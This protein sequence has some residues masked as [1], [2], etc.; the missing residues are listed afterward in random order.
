MQ[1]FIKNLLLL[2]ATTLF[3][4]SYT[5][6]QAQNT[7]VDLNTYGNF[8][9]P[10][11][12]GYNVTNYTIINPMNGTSTP[13]KYALTTD[14]KLMNSTY[15][16][17]GDHTTGTGKMM[18]IDGATLDN[19]FFWTT[20]SCGC[21]IQGFTVG[22]TYTFSFWVKSVSND[23]T[24]LTQS[25]IQPLVPV[26]VAAADQNPPNIIVPLPALGWQ[27]V[28]FTFTAT[29]T[30]V[31]IRLKTMSI[32]NAGNDF[33]VD[34]FSII[35]GTL[36]LV[37]S[38]DVPTP[39]D[40]TCPDSSDGSITA[41]VNFGK[42]P[43]SYTITGPKT[44]TNTSGVFNSLPVG[45]Y[46]ISVKDS[47]SPPTTITQP[48]PITLSG[49]PNDLV[50][51]PDTSACPGKSTTLT[52][53]GGK[54]GYT[55]T[56]SPT[57]LSLTT[58]NDASISVSPTQTTTYTV[59]SGLTS[60]PTNFIANGDFSF[61][62]S[63]FT[64]DYKFTSNPA[65]N[66]QQKCYGIVSNPKTWFN[67]FSA[68][69]DHTTG[70]DKMFVA[71]GATSL[72]KVWSQNVSGLLPNQDYDFSY[73]IQSLTSGT[74]AKMEVL[75][76]GVSLGPLKNAPASNCQ[77]KL[78]KYIWNSG[79]NT[80]ATITIYNRDLSGG[81][82]DF[83]ID[84]IAFT[85]SVYCIFKKT[86]TITIDSSVD[87]II[88]P[89]G[90]VCSPV[91]VDI[92]D[93]SITAGS[94]LGTLS[95]WIDDQ[96]T[97]PLTNPDTISV[98]GTY[99]IKN[100]VSSCFIIK[101]VT[102][103][104]TNSGSIAAPTVS[105]PVNYCQNDTPVALTATP[106]SGAT[107]N[108]YGSNAIG[109][110]ASSTAP[111]PSTSAVGPPISYYVS[112][113]TG[114]CES[115]RAKIDVIMSPIPTIT[116]IKPNDR[117]GAGSV[118]LEATASTGAAVINWYDAPS[119]GI[120]LGTGTTF[121]TPSITTNT[122]YYV[123]A[124][125]NGCTTPATKAVLASIKPIPVLTITCVTPTV[126]SVTFNW[127]LIADA[128]SYNYSY[129]VASGTPVLG[130]V[131]GSTS[132]LT[133]NGLSAG[134]NAVITITPVGSACGASTNANCSALNCSSPTL[135]VS[136][137]PVCSGTSATV[138]ATPTTSGTYSYAWTVPSGA[139]NP[140]NIASFSTTVTGNYS[141]I[142]TDITTSCPSASTS[143]T[144]TI[145]PLPTVTVSAPPI[146][147]GASATVTA[148]PGTTGNYNYVWTVPS[149]ATNPG[150]V[151]SFQTTVV[152]NYS[153]IITDTVSTC[154]SASASGTITINTVPTVSVNNPSV[155]S[156]ASATVTATSGTIGTYD[157]TWTVPA[158]ATNPG[159]IASFL[160]TIP[161]SYGVIIADKV[162]TCSSASTSGIV[163]ANVLPTVS[164]N[165]PS[166][167]SGA[168]A[169]VTAT[170]ATTGSY[171]YSWTVPSGA[172]NPGNVA[173]F[174]TT[175][176]GN[177]SLIM[178]DNVST[179]ASASVSVNVT[180]NAIPDVLNPP[181]LQT[182][183][184]GEN[185]GVGLL[186]SVAGTTFS[187]TVISTGVTGASA[188]NGI[189]ISQVLT[190]SGISSG[191]VDYTVTPTA[192]GCVGTPVVISLI[193]APNPV[194]ATIVASSS[195]CSGSATNIKLSSTIASTTYDWNVIQ[196]NSTGATAGSGDKIIQKISTVGNQSGEVVYAI[197]PSVNGCSGS[198]SIIPISVNPIP[199]I[200][201]STNFQT[202]C[203]GGSTN[204]L[205]SSEV[206][207]TT[208]DWTV[209]QTGVLGGLSGN[210][211]TIVQTLTTTDI[212]EGFA[213]YV[214]TPKFNGCS[215]TP[216][217]VEVKVNPIPAIF[218]NGGSDICS[219]NYTN[220][221]LI[222]NPN[223][224]LTTFEWTANPIDVTGSKDDSGEDVIEQLLETVTGGSVTYTV[225]PS[226]G[227]CKGNSSLVKINVDPIPKPNL[228]DGKIC[229][230]KAT[231]NT[232]NPYL[233]ETDL[234]NPN[235]EFEWYFESVKIPG[236]TQN[237]YEASE[238]GEYSVLVFNNLTGCTSKETFATMT[239][240]FPANSYTIEQTTAFTENASITI[241]VDGD[242]NEYLYKLDDGAW[243]SLN[244]FSGISS[245]LHT[246]S[247]TD[248]EGCTSF[249]DTVTIIDYPKF[250]TPNGDGFNDTWNVVGLGENANAK[251]SIYDR[252]GK[253]VK[254]ISSD[255]T[256]W[257]GTFNN[258]LLPATDYW[259]T[260][261][262]F[263]N[264]IEKLFKAHFS[265][266]R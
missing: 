48:T 149:G 182:I 148:T 131:S 88:T 23:V 119:G 64:T 60:N 137:S 186:S 179:C 261:N 95:Y 143:G 212:K 75:I 203:S 202:I 25:V 28:G 245:G 115:P 63:D 46:T 197:T 5:D 18:V 15:I 181:S 27:Q 17:G 249:T 54:G 153:V 156:G 257:D 90:A 213:E 218:G 164:V 10:L 205:L 204:I 102:V 94:T 178:T 112:Q 167:C 51:S 171:T 241:T 220:I 47:N 35:K 219:G 162:T 154:S 141:A 146:C 29:D 77:W 108:W 147:S 214:I 201:A 262:Y 2:F 208:F 59:T 38:N 229:I 142:I 184:S 85:E 221:K 244:V 239:E 31:M 191:T 61:G 190:A 56:A 248:I 36:P 189:I 139:T 155:C 187:W 37:F 210:D 82:N 223:I 20:G 134:Q 105:T 234:S 41:S 259:F 34:D 43:Y 227:G 3:I 263:E 13:G 22:E 130:S 26:G 86:T 237:S 243:Q 161:G 55:W 224:P 258:Q 98:G 177:Y 163:T 172:T 217:S 180:E 70:I 33:A 209:I 92:T 150:N 183:C 32:S 128:T 89:P 175:A 120:L 188:G 266:K 81:G 196:S 73:Y 238:I 42:K 91:T 247:I 11:Y 132:T 185:T 253:L 176:I 125:E 6:I 53:S 207:L 129:S 96:A 79:S 4:V 193:V 235:F 122:T 12:T 242:L 124:T 83:A 165:S 192:N 138:T 169:T 71:D 200:S 222:P 19:Q 99:Y 260:I 84:D 45:T 158:G 7:L 58:P 144:V 66:G 104:I 116:S 123:A 126:T 65:A 174:S 57:D 62:N 233:I 107:L 215:G 21:P 127:N 152:G 87:L 24:S 9:G 136:A 160:T 93:S 80:S 44:V 14:P 225:T 133:V 97:N 106:L 111:T 194:V 76:N 49:P 199:E 211:S 121:A 72:A 16:S 170:P 256:G 228:K 264:K 50:V 251:L 67:A 151:A 118:N 159:N 168:S 100:T 230:E 250:F 109:G 135:T 101:P 110:V 232:L 1:N 195:I 68:C 216:L 69:P 74:V 8:Q 166:V 30:G 78:H 40:P 265:L 240:T 231:G 145:N 103:T 173:S 252:Y 114:T 246:I 52:A 39:T 157:Y 140:G 113:T 226:Y 236:A 254:Q 255:G 206:G 198:T 117:C